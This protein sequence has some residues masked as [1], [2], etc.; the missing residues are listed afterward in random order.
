MR[1]ELRPLKGSLGIV[2]RQ[3]RR[4]LRSLRGETEGLAGEES[5]PAAGGEGPGGTRVVA[6]STK[7]LLQKPIWLNLKRRSGCSDL[8]HPIC[9]L[10]QKRRK[11]RREPERLF[12]Y[13]VKMECS[14]NLK[15]TVPNKR[16]EGTL[17]FRLQPGQRFQRENENKTELPPSRL[18]S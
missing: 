18:S 16:Q 14:I 5:S 10:H 11:I 13:A 8:S 17:I 15:A 12:S 9:G 2:R 6:S 1:A 3:R 7:I 4:R